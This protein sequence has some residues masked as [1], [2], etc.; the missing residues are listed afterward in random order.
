MC[1][2]DMKDLRLVIL[3]TRS[4]LAKKTFLFCKTLRKSFGICCVVSRH[5]ALL[6]RDGTEALP[7]PVALGV[8]ALDH[9]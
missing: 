7:L 9:S 1:E 5:A 4:L 6:A 8:N 3:R 2:D